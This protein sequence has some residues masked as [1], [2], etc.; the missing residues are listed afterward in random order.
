[1]AHAARART[2]RLAVLIAGAALFAFGVD[3]AAGQTGP[4]RFERTY[5]ARIVLSV[6]TTAPDTVY[7]EKATHTY[8]RVRILFIVQAS[9]LVTAIPADYAKSPANG[10]MS[11][12]IAYQKTG[13]TPCTDSKRFSGPARMEIG[14]SRSVS[15]VGGWAGPPGGAELN[16]GSKRKCRDAIDFGGG[17]V[18]DYE[19]GR[20]F[21]QASS[22][23]GL[24]GWAITRRPIRGRLPFPLNRLYAGRSFAATVSG[25]TNDGFA[26]RQGAI[27]VTFTARA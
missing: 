11:G 17:H 1:M 7:L 22:V 26:V 18:W 2:S 12:S 3:A 15:A 6:T 5:D 13:S 25:T 23:D 20:I 27:R 10:V 9:G 8:R 19:R 4:K 16:R 21:A 24:V 14:A